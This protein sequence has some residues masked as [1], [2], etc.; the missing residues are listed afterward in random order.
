MEEGRIPK[1][2][3]EWE[4]EERWQGESPR[5]NGFTVYEQVFISKGD[6]NKYGLHLKRY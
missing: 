2:E 4:P 3:T 6:I 1:V 5:R